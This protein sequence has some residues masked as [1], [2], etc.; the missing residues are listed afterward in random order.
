M[1]EGEEQEHWCST[2]PWT[3]VAAPPKRSRAI[4]RWS[5]SVLYLV[6]VSSLASLS[7]CPPRVFADDTARCGDGIVQSAIGEECDDG[8]TCVGGANAG[9]HCTAESDCLGNG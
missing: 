3:K 2:K 1:G 4:M 8:G 5:R 7:P 9:T 6:A